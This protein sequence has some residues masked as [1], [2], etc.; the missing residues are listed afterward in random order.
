VTAKLYPAQ[1]TRAV[2]LLGDE[3]AQD[4]P[5]RIANYQG[6]K[7][8][9][10]SCPV[11]VELFYRFSLDVLARGY[12]H[13]SADALWHRMRF[14]TSIQAGPEHA[15]D[16]AFNN[17]HRTFFARVMKYIDPKVHALFEFRDPK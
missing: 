10:A 6:F 5:Q 2:K 13:Y 8:F 9:V 14:E 1:I 7:A 16:Y 11:S 12:E 3:I 15:K 4:T 17:N